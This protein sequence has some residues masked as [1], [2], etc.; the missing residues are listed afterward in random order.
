MSDQNKGGG[1]RMQ[2]ITTAEAKV[3]L[4]KQ[5]STPVEPETAPARQ[6]STADT[7]LRNIFFRSGPLPISPD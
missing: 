7:L 6:D 1:K 5:E 4:G 3:K 2:K